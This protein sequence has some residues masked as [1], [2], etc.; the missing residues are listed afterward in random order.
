MRYIYIYIYIGKWFAYYKLDVCDGEG[1][2]RGA[3]GELLA[4][5][6]ARENMQCARTHA[7]THWVGEMRQ[8][9]R[10]G[11]KEGG[12]D[13]EREGARVCVCLCVRVGGGGADARAAEAAGARVPRR[14]RVGELVRAHA[15]AH[16]HAHGC[17]PKSE[18][19][20]TS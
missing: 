15:R 1:R 20:S 12:R 11:E 3:G 16:T 8:G 6:C 13:R 9:G 17:A 10:E 4:C 19:K 7:S 14:R 2:W 5:M 18:F